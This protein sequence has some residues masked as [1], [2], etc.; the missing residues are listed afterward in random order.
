MTRQLQVLLVIYAMRAFILF[1]QLIRVSIHPLTYLWNKLIIYFY[2]FLISHLFI[3]SH[4]HRSQP[5]NFYP[6]FGLR[7]TRNIKCPKAPAFSPRSPSF[8]NENNRGYQI[9]RY[10]WGN[11]FDFPRRFARLI[12][13]RRDAHSWNKVTTVFGFRLLSV[14][15]L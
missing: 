12:S 7:K 6:S 3:T 5:H 11:R 10:R 1:Q 4:R 15:L 2:F 9:G 13:G 14:L 8:I